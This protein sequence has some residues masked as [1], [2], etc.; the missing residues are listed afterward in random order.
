MIFITVGTTKFL[1]PRMLKMID[2]AL[3]ALETKEKVIAQIGNNNYK[4]S[5]KY[6]ETYNEFPFNKMLYYISH[7]RIV[8][9]HG[10][11]GTMLLVLRHAKNKPIV[12]PRT[13][14]FNEHIDNHQE[15]YCKF[16]K[17]R[18]LAEIIFKNEN[19]TQNILTYLKSPKTIAGNKT[20][21]K[22]KHF[23]DRLTAY[24]KEQINMKA[25]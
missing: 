17:N 19:E 14:L 7:A 2:E 5:Y 11:C 18:R 9:S 10:G 1:F 4:F 13:K 20:V 16:L 22:L 6:T 12:I 23:T 25:E 21:N 24:T 3:L 15:Y 8:I